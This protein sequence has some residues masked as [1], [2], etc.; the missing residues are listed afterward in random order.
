MS[1]SELY[2]AGKLDEAIAAQVQGV[3]ASPGDPNKRLF[4]F[5]L[6]LF[7][8]DLE[9]AKRQLDAVRYDEP[10]RDSMVDRYRRLLEA[11]EFRRRVFREGI[12]PQFLTA[13]PE[14]LGKRLQ[15]IQWLRGGQPAEA[16]KVL[17]EAD[18]AAGAAAGMLNGKAFTLLCDADGLF[19]PTLEVMAHADYYWLP[20]EQVET[21]ALNPPK[22]PRDLVYLPARLSVKGGPTGEV[23]L[24][25]LYPGSHEAADPQLKL[26]RMTDWKAPA[27]GEEAPARGVGAKLFLVDD[28]AVPLLEWR[29]LQILGVVPAQGA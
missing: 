26:A 6:L 9:R 23:F 25:T 4:L 14:H 15:A 2:Q 8:G 28:D 22:F 20:L 3:K 5:E 17:R 7:A 12:L 13:P 19:G 27:E 11:E 10:E 21:L 24:P 29:E 1:A 16:M 18:A